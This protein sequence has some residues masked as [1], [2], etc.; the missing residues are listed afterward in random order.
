MVF[1]STSY[2]ASALSL[3]TAAQGVLTQ[4]NN[5][6][7]NP[8]GI[9]MYIDVPNN[10][11]ANAPIIVALH[12]C[13]GSAQGYY[14]GNNLA[15]V[16]KQRGAIMIYPSST[17]DLL[18]WDCGTRRSLIRDGGG[19]PQSIVQM[20]QYIINRYNADASRVFVVGT[21]SGAMMGNV[22]AAVYPDV[23]AATS[24]YSGVAAGRMAVPDGVPPNPYDPCGLGHIIR[25][26][27]D[28]GNTVRGYNPGYTGSYP[29]M[30]IWH[31]TADTTV[32]YQ[33]F[34]EDLKEWSN[35]HGVS[36]TRNVTN[37]PQSGYT[38]MIYGDGQ[39]LTGYSARGVGHTV[40]VYVSQAL[41][42]FGL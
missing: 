14:Q 42:F 16:A 22:L 9:E 27:Q 15:T 20:V 13:H 24:V 28:W 11:A 1:L 31:G 2:L 32:V 26:P 33:N 10:V 35:V 34:I 23:F 12:G 29:R 19:D 39:R 41:N 37:S 36:F 25:S 8:A 17:H 6:G 4:V 3:F 38:Q 21:S 30:Q 7:S 18:C 40:P 5:F